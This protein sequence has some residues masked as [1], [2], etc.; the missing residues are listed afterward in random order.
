MKIILFLCI[1]FSTSIA[2]SY[3]A[4]LVKLLEFLRK[5]CSAFFPIIASNKAKE[6]GVSNAS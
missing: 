5:K 2:L 6:G 4:A 1:V 3:A